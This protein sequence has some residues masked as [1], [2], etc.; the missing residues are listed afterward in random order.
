MKEAL[1][2]FSTAKLA[3]EKGFDWDC[4]HFYTVDEVLTPCLAVRV[5]EPVDNIVSDSNHAIR[6]YYSA[7]TQ[8]LL[9]KWLRDVHNIQMYVETHTCST[10]T[11]FGRIWKDYVVHAKGAALNDA[12]D[13]EYQTYEDA[14]EFGLQT[15]LKSVL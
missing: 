6:L 15:M 13:E 11:E 5:Y 8:S 7:P 3:K 12:R 9:Q 1:I 4:N 10:T 14:L 2:E